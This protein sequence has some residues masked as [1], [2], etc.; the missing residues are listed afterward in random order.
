MLAA[1]PND[2]VTILGAARTPFGKFG[3]ALRS[4]TLPD[5]GSHA[6]AA[7]LE[8][9]GV[10]QAD[11]DELAFGINFPGSDRSI[12]RQVALRAGIPD[13]RNAYTVDR[14]CCS[15]L[16]A[17]G[18]AVRSVRDGD[19]RVAVA[20]GAE[21]LS[22]VP[23]FL[24]DMRWGHALGRVELV[25][26]LVIACPHTGVARA[27]QA[28]D[29]AAEFGVGREQQ[30]E[31]ALRSQQRCADAISAGRFRDEIAP[32][33]VA[34][35]GEQRLVEADESPRPGT[36]LEALARLPTVNGSA[37]VTAG[38]APGLS[39]GATA[40]V[41]ASAAEAERRGVRPLATVV[42]TA[43]AS[44]P[45]ARIAS[46]PAVTARKALERAGIGLEDVALI[47]INEAFAAVPLVATLELARGDRAQAERLRERTNVNGGAVAIGHPTGATGA[48]LVMT[49]AFELARRGGG[50]GLVTIC[51]GIGE[52]QAAVIRVDDAAHRDV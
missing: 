2:S 46:I 41:L 8:R 26:Q 27:V 24:E 29:E 4:L 52:G 20:G 31:W 45:P 50:F 42:A 40:L 39:T 19:A 37:T 3:G 36:S 34:L 6:V 35:D 7:A 5:L 18:L 10:A 23:Y 48:R 38:N 33:E 22:R 14:A 13:D 43:M 1:R 47:E 25:D 16:A 49:V 44:G 12:A 28:A 15:S 51:G 21:N 30:D 32:I 17:V 9:A 11:V